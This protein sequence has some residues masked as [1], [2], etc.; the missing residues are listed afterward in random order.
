MLAANGEENKTE[1]VAT[2]EN[3]IISE[4]SMRH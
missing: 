3:E 4:D 1:V 2:G